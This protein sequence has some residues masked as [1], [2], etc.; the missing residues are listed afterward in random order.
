MGRQVSTGVN[1]SGSILGSIYASGQN[2]ITT[3]VTNQDIVIDPN[4]SGTVQFVGGIHL[5]TAGEMR[6]Y[7]TANTYYSSVKALAGLSANT[8]FQLPSANGTSGQF[9][10]TDGAGATSWQSVPTAALTVS[11]AGSNSNTHFLYFGT[12]TTPEGSLP[13][14]AQSTM[15]VDS[16]LTFIPSENRLVSSIGQ[17]PTV[18]GSSGASGTLTIN[19]TTNSTKATAS[20]LMT[21]AVASTS[22]TTG[23]LVI[24]GGAG[25][26]GNLNVG[27]NIVMNSST[28]VTQSS[29]ATLQPTLGTNAVIRTNSNTINETITIPAGTNGMSAG[30]ITIASGQTVTVNGDWSVV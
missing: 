25:I 15:R 27:G 6:A 21:D 9:L 2:T 8:I 20:I 19:G 24:T 23:T 3:A 18:T 4:G 7:N 1:G 12:S 22:T 29:L 13:T 5:K 14:G 11:D 16:G 17:H 26:S 30:P 28:V 10:Q